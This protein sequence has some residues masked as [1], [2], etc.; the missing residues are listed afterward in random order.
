MLYLL[1]LKEKK[2]RETRGRDGC[3]IFLLHFVLVGGG[4]QICRGR[5]GII[6][7]VAN[8]KRGR[9]QRGKASSPDATTELLSQPALG[10]SPQDFLS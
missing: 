6:S 5:P 10:A 1:A 2:M 8:A 3:L 9:R 4:N 7:G